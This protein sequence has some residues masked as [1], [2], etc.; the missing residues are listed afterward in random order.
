VSSSEGSRPESLLASLHRA[1]FGIIF[2]ACTYALSVGTGM[3]MVHS[4]N[5]PALA[6]RDSLV[7]RA[8]RRDPSALANDAGAPGRAAALDFARSLGLAAVP[9]TV[10]G[11]TLVLPVASAAYR[12]WVGGVVSV[13]G[14]HR[15]RLRLPASALYYIVTMLLQLSG[16]TL[17]GGAGLHLGMAYFRREGPFVGP[18][19]FRLPW[20]ALVDVGRL[21]LLIVPLFAVGSVWEYYFPQP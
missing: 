11:L 14:A 21:Y 6:F 9:E 5:V 3:V 15:S 12:G 18:T 8:H 4:G 1:R 16:F 2:M 7:A 20:P 19:W 10:A 17:A 13:D